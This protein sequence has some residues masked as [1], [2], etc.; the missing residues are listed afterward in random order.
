MV[1]LL[2]F[3]F[4]VS[5][6]PTYKC[7]YCYLWHENHSL[8]SVLTFS[9][10]NVICFCH[11]FSTPYTLRE[12]FRWLRA[13]PNLPFTITRL[14]ILKHS[15][16]PSLPLQTSHN[17]SQGQLSTSTSPHFHCPFPHSGAQGRMGSGLGLQLCISR[18][19]IWS[20]HSRFIH[21]NQIHEAES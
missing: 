9:I 17:G 12:E 14:I 11:S 13:C 8:N 3:L 6:L 2:N 5:P 16:Q 19:F 21:T 10:C 18:N 20:V 15:H 4:S 1:F 7:P